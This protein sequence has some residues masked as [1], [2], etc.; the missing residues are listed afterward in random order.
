MERQNQEKIRREIRLNPLCPGFLKIIRSAN[1]FHTYVSDD[2]KNWYPVGTS[3]TL[4]FSNTV[5]IG[6]AVSAKGIVG[7]AS[8]V[9]G[10]VSVKS[11]AKLPGK[12]KEKDKSQD[13]LNKDIGINGGK[14]RMAKGALMESYT[15]T[16]SNNGINRAGKFH[17][18]YKKF[19]GDFTF[20]AQLTS[21]TNGEAGL[22]VRESLQEE[23]KMVSLLIK[24]SAGD[25][26]IRK[27]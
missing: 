14:V 21:Q 15:I 25:F 16:S 12:P 7:E 19:N 18:M 2:N 5:Y 11:S 13:W 8:A 17:Y 6:L 9:F 20:L 24:N 23:S 22:M 1:S 10:G 26:S 3:Q 4:N 27:R